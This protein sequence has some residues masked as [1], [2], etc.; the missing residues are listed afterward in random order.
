M[1]P[2]TFIPALLVLLAPQLAAAQEERITSTRT[3]TTTNT[4]TMTIIRSVATSTTMESTVTPTPA[5]TGSDPP[6]SNP[7]MV[8]AAPTGLPMMMAGG[9]AVLLGAVV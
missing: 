3:T 2:F 9:I 8:I 1:K 6:T 7:A 5:A 4:V